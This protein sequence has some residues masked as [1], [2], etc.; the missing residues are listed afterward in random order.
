MALLT[1]IIENNMWTYSISIML[2]YCCSLAGEAQESRSAQTSSGDE[3]AGVQ[4]EEG[5]TASLPVLHQSLPPLSAP[6]ESVCPT[7][8]QTLSWE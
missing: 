5:G 4:V 8:T 7:L 2:S 3:V 1:S 6:A